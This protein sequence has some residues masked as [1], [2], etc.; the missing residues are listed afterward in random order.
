MKKH[1]QN[2]SFSVQLAIE[3]G[4]NA[5]IVFN[6]LHYWINHNRIVGTAQADGKTWTYQSRLT[7]QEYLPYLT[8]KEVRGA[9]DKLVEYGYVIKGKFNKN[10]FDQTTWYSLPDS[11]PCKPERD[12]SNILYESDEKANA[13]DLRVRSTESERANVSIYKDMKEDMKTSSS[14]PDDDEKKFKL[15]D[16][17]FNSIK[18]K[19]DWLP[20]EI[21]KAWESY[22]KYSVNVEN[23]LEYIEAI[24]QKNRII[25]QNQSSKGKICSKKPEITETLQEK[26]AN[27]ARKLLENATETNI[28]ET[29][30]QQ[31]REKYKKRFC[32]S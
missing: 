6:H 26:R 16:I 27:S 25:K 31:E 18:S 13:L 30:M 17:H 28:L 11:E 24:I 4:I 22:Q 21:E 14:R 3:C 12:D 29:Y 1:S 15:S 2:H 20:E 8:E 19:K 7:M 10:K 5:A 9:I 23:P 32:L